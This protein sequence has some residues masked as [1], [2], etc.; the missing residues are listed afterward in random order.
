MNSK[1]T[2]NTLLIL[3][4]PG[5]LDDLVTDDVRLMCAEHCAALGMQA[6]F[7]VSES[8]DEIAA[9]IR[10]SSENCAG[11]I[12]NPRGGSADDDAMANCSSALADT[13]TLNR[14]TIEVR[15]N[16]VLLESSTEP[17]PMQVPDCKLGFVAGL[18]IAGYGLAIKAIAHQLEA[19]T[20]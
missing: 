4:G 13:A 14:P 3:N 9:W 8:S 6:D 18:G 11:L 19:G 10:D 20:V 15:V 17:G 16:N 12:L 1:V 2:S 7:R 5:S